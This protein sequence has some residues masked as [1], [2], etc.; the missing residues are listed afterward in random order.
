M[1]K[2]ALSI[3][4][5]GIYCLL[6]G[7]AFIFIPNIFI[8]LL[9]F[10]PTYDMWIKVLGATLLAI[11][12]Y[13]IQSARTNN[14]AFFKISVPGRIMASSLF[15]VLALLGIVEIMMALLGLIEFGCALWTWRLLRNQ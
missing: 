2:V 9:G 11:A 3:L 7:F 15:I 4:L 13:Y 10:E 1:S 12:F 5:F 8:T 14:I 6:A